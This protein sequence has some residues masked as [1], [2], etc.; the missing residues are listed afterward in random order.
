MKQNPRA[1]AAFIITRWE[2]SRLP[3][4]RLLDEELPKNHFAKTED[5]QLCRALVFGVVRWL[6]YLD[7]VLG[8][9]SKHP[10]AGMKA[11]IRQALRVALFQMLFMDRIPVSAAINEAV[12]ILKTDGQ[13]RWLTGFVNGV[14]RNI[15]RHSSELPK[16]GGETGYPPH[17]LHSYPQWLFGRWRKRYGEARA[18]ELCKAGNAPAP[19]C[20][21]AVEPD[22][23]CEELNKSGV[24]AFRGKYAPLA[25]ILPDFRG[26]VESLPGYAEGA[27]Q[28][29]DEA[30]Q[31]ASYL[32]GVKG[33]VRCLDGCAGLG[34]KT[35]HLAA[36]LPEGSTLVAVEPDL[37]RRE[38]LQ[39]NLARLGLAEGVAVFGG[40]LQDLAKENKEPF[41]VV[42][43]DAPC[44]GL[45]VI[46][47]HPDIR[48]NRVPEDPARYQETQLGLL[49]GAA[50][51][52]APG[53]IMVYA[54]CSTEPQEN[55]AVVDAFLAAHPDFTL[56]NCRD[57]LQEEALPLVDE[58]GFFHPLP[59]QG[60][61]GFFAAR[62]ERSNAKCKMQNVK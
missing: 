27:F 54:T 45:G 40:S 34:G 1:I 2:E 55:E 31:L 46:R 59:D 58:R 14:L 49:A 5:S 8:Q 24:R 9:F 13:P 3:I 48:W 35:T 38:L 18:I 19:L 4:S 15:D 33:P 60:L 17:I 56:S 10:L 16:A 52:L 57:Y 22:R 50:G 53:G 36:L 42:L 23:L 61:D 26:R 6:G 47:H 30:A 25:V 37:R 29:Q 21:R 39:Q 51:L 32:V 41:D 43:I 11:E 7:H 12:K 20:L 28:V 44:S 62:L